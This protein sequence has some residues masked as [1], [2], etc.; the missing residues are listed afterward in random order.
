MTPSTFKAIRKRAGL[1]Q[2][3]L[4]AQVRVGDR[5]IRNIESGDRAPSGPLIVLMEQ[6]E[7]GLPR[8]TN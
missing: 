8:D 1:S 2:R 3:Q 6:L 7:A 5:H 4:A